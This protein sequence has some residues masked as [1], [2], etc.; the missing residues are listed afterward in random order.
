MINTKSYIQPV[1]ILFMTLIGF[2]CPNFSDA[3]FAK[4]GYDEKLLFRGMT[5][6]TIGATEQEITLGDYGTISQFSS[7]ISIA[8]PVSQRILFTASNSGATTSRD[9]GGIKVQGLVDTRLS[10]SFVLPGDKVWLTAGAS[11]P[12][13]KTSLSSEQ[14]DMSTY[15]SQAALGYGVPI[16]GQGVNGN[17]GIAYASSIT[18][19][20]VFGVGSSYSYRGA[21]TPVN[22]GKEYDPGDEITANAGIDYTTYSK[23]ARFSADITG[24]YYLQDT[25]NGEKIFQSGPRIMAFLAYYLKTGDYSHL[26]S[27]RIRYRLYNTFYHDSTTKEYSG[28]IQSEFRYSLTTQLNSWLTGNVVFEPRLYTGDQIEFGTGV[29]ETG[30]ALIVS[31]GPD[32]LF[33]VSDIIIPTLSFRYLAGNITIDGGKENVSGFE[34]GIGIKVSF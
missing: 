22:G 19:R 16:F 23:E 13:G 17:F 25:Y 31:I 11:I 7:P 32:F 18:R 9:S 15:T 4:P 24:A 1:H 28:S 3:Q 6:V 12:T 5:G 10:L 21:Y 34:A 27:V 26:M 14:L 29:V 8:V 20:L 30:K 33:T 2:V